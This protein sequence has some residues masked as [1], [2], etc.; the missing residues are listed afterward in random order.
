MSESQQ[1]IVSCSIHGDAKSE[2]FVCEH[3]VAHTKLGFYFDIDDQN[4]PFPDAWC[5]DCEKIRKKYGGWNDFSE[6]LIKVNLVCGEC[7]EQ[8]KAKNILGTEVQSS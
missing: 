4:N 5:G 7:Y 6:A 1:N 8:I 2:A 3:L